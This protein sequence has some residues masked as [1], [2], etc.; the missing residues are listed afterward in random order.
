M[1]RLLLPVEV[2]EEDTMS[3]FERL[4]RLP[5]QPLLSLPHLLHQL[6]RSV[7]VLRDPQ[8]KV[9]QEDEMECG[10]L[11]CQWRRLWW[12]DGISVR[13]ELDFQDHHHYHQHRYHYYLHSQLPQL[14]LL[15]LLHSPSP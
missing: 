12:M 10:R 13:E 7:L 14:L 3:P 1:L 4:P 8:G 5:Q 15:L 9:M 6:V 2:M 11:Q